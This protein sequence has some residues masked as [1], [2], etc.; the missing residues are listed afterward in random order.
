MKKFLSIFVLCVIG[1]KI[2]T[3]APLFH[4]TIG[5]MW[6]DHF[7]QYSEEQKKAF[8]LG[9]LFPDIR[10][11][12]KISRTKTHEKGL[13]IT[14]LIEIKD[15]FTKG[16]KLHSYVDEVR[17]NYVDKHL[18]PPGYR[19]LAYA[20]QIRIKV[21]ED[22]V[23]Y[24]QNRCDKKAICTFLSTPIKEEEI[25]G[26]T[27]QVIQQ[28]HEHMTESFTGSPSEN[29]PGHIE[30]EEGHGAISLNSTKELNEYVQKYRDDPIVIAHTNALMAHFEKLFT[31][32]KK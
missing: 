32:Y 18:L 9:T 15:P 31:D 3:A 26:V 7:E 17:D 22:E 10:Y 13:T 8:M 19:H 24:S 16:M 30:R 2:H 20:P 11:M 29:L 6:I 25:H 4:A 27:P 1:V 28:W 21:L 23:L 14:D 12:A 5:Q